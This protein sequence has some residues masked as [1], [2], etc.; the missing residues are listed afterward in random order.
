MYI[1]FYD[2]NDSLIY[3]FSQ[4][5][6]KQM[7]TPSPKPVDLNASY[8]NVYY[9]TESEHSYNFLYTSFSDKISIGHYME[10]INPN[11]LKI[12]T[13]YNIKS[14]TIML[15]SSGPNVG[16]VTVGNISGERSI[17]LDELVSNNSG[18][19]IKLINNAEG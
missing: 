1:D 16:T 17:P 5:Q 8:V 6:L 12:K 9:L 4:S 19:T 14:M 15:E 3:S 7:V 10:L 13:D 11:S 18:Y 2:K